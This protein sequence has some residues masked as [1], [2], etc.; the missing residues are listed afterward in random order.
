[1]ISKLS[2]LYDGSFEGLLTAVWEAYYAKEDPS[3]IIWEGVS[4]PNLL[5]STKM[6]Y[7]DANKA[8]RVYRAVE[9]KISHAALRRI[10]YI[11]LSGEPESGIIVLNYLRI[12]FRLG[13]AVDDYHAEPTV[14]K[15]E[16][17]Y[18]KVAM[19]KHRQ[20]G[21]IRFKRLE[22]GV[23]YSKIDPDH[24]VIALLAPHF[25]ARMPSEYWILHDAG[26]GI[27]VFYDKNDWVV[28]NLETPEDIVLKEEEETYQEMWKAYYRHLSIE[29][30]K[31]MSL[32]KRMMPVRYWKNLI[33][34]GIELW[35]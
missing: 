34:E 31:N 6:I 35:S 10:F 28:R 17:L 1:M 15:S 27:A 11:Y 13:A 21:L 4:H 30:R 9:E 5:S 24:N 7:T 14:L 2:Y 19:E 16:K 32:K 18:N 20:A 23:F 22:S 12:G 25:A 8:D 29:S 33:E 26:R 3:E